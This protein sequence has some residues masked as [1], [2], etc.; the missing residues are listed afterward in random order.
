MT[1]INEIAQQVG[2]DLTGRPRIAHCTTEN[3]T[4]FAEL[5]VQNCITICENIGT[6]QDGH[7]CADKIKEHFSEDSN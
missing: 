4:K 2:I 5:L 1:K 7:V 3:I 6:K